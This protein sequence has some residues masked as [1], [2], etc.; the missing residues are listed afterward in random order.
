MALFIAS[1]ALGQ[2]F[3]TP[4]ILA[5]EIAYIV[6]S[7]LAMSLLCD[8]QMGLRNVVR[9]D[10]VCLLSLYGLILVERLTIEETFDAVNTV[11]ATESG[12]W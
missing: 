8:A 4:S 1:T 6:G 3:V 2:Q 11:A 12:R 7:G 9:A 5:Q 10:T